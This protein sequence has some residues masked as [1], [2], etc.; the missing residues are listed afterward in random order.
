MAEDK[1]MIDRSKYD[2]QTTRVIGKDGKVRHSAGNG[3]AIAR[4]LL[5]LAHDEIVR[6]IKQNGLQ[7]KLGK[8]IDQVNPGQL[9]MF[10]GNSLRGMVRRGEAVTVGKHVIKSLDQHVEVDEAPPAGAKAEKAPPKAAKKGSTTSAPAK[11]KRASKKA[12]EAA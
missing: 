5:G 7:D 8:H 10:V 1:K 4:A 9:R 2:Y 3:D 11:G 12:L 6:V